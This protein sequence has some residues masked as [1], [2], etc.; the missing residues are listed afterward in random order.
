M[1]ILFMPSKVQQWLMEMECAD[2]LLKLHQNVQKP[3]RMGFEPTRAEHIGLAVQ[4]FN[5]LATSSSWRRLSP[6]CQSSL[7]GWAF[8]KLIEC[9][10][11]GR[12]D[13]RYSSRCWKVRYLGIRQLSETI[14]Y[15]LLMIPRIVLLF[16]YAKV[17]AGT[18]PSLF[19]SN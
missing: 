7:P 13:T 16:R 3:M 17:L 4:R 14:S 11:Y 1:T 10:R 2:R 15:P 6:P 9:T 19:P 12:F 18:C 5:N 8:S